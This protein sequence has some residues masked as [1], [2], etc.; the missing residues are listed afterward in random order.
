M[1]GQKIRAVIGKGFGDEGKGLAVDYFCS[2]IP[3][4]LVIKH[5]GGA[6][7]GHTVELNGKRFVFHQLAAGSFRHCDTFWA[8]SYYPDLYK[9][10]EEV[11]GFRSM[12]GFCPRIL[13]DENTPVTFIDD[14]L[15]NVMLETGRGENRHGSCGMGINEAFL[16]TQAGFGLRV[17]DF[18][19]ES[20]SALVQRILETR[21]EYVRKRLE[22]AGLVNLSGEVREY[23]ELLSSRVVAENAVEEM[24][25]SAEAYVKVAENTERLLRSKRQIVF[26]GGQGLL[27]DSENE[28]YAPHVTASRTGLINPVALLD[29]CGLPMTEAV[30]V[31]RT[32]VTRHGAGR[33]PNEC[34]MEELGLG[35]GDRTNI[36]NPWQGKLRYA[37]HGGLEEFLKPVE[38]DLKAAG[39]KLG[40]VSL[41]LTHL[42]E[43]ENKICM[44]EGDLEVGE[45]L[46]LLKVREIFDACYLSA[47]RF[48]KDVV[49]A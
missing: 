10:R 19:S 23:G 21:E 16:R 33:L 14:V 2:L 47:S 11:E 44:E 39:E 8:D 17:K 41:F 1:S 3:E 38:E 31:T 28:T 7:A 18:L 37:R 48:G 34:A 22:E 42:N 13:C 20:A 9:L 49:R 25:R 29:R 27:L 35:E 24:L 45:F 30:Y 36:E 12:A 40:K 32:Y 15:I 43:T 26:E 5:N 6:Q 4:T 46:E